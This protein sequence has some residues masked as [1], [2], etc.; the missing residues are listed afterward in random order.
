[1]I[2]NSAVANNP[3]HCLQK[4]TGG[5]VDKQPTI[6]GYGRQ[7]RLTLYLKKPQELFRGITI[8]QPV[9]SRRNDGLP[10]PIYDEPWPSRLSLNQAP[11]IAQRDI[12]VTW[13]CYGA[14]SEG[15]KFTR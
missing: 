1:M 11:G 5:W 7:Q 14:Y 4:F 13:C 10:T 12:G 8:S 6:L 9:A 15:P 2:R 3:A